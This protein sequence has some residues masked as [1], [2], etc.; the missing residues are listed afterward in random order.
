MTATEQEVGTTTEFGWTP[1]HRDLRDAVRR[2]LATR[3]PLSRARELA[4]SGTRHDPALW[5][6]LAEQLGLQGL[7]IPTDLGGSGASR[8]ELAI[9]MEEMGAVLLGGPFLSTVVLAAEALLASSDEAAQAEHLP[10]IAAGELTAT[11]AVVEADGRWHEDG[12]AT[13]A[14]GTGGDVRLTGTKEIVLDGA[15]AELLIVAARGERGVSLYT[16]DAGAAGLDRERLAVLDLTRPL[17]RITLADTP[18]TL[19]GTDGAGWAVV[20]QVRRAATIL[21]AAEQVGASTTVVAMT[22]EYAKTRRQFGRP[23]GSF[24]GVKHRLAD[25]AVRLEM[26]RSAAYWAAWQT[27]GSDDEALGAAVA[28]SYCSDSF[29]QS[30]KDMIQ[31][32]GGIGF[33]WE[34]DSHLFLRRARL[35]ASVVGGSAEHRAALLPLILPESTEASA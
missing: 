13:V 11:L 1:E 30:A 7:A 33:T 10:R 31:L 20:E 29:L 21:V 32:H 23:I 22:A 15:D 35:D 25:M 24:Q 8:L 3:A 19:L 17:A 6:V 28:G 4:E 18:A 14:T 12:I 26:S 34:H 5:S 9:A 27:P 2:V 16:V